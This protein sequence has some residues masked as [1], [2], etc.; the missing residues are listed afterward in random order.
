MPV[1]THT[2]DMACLPAF[3]L[4]PGNN[5]LLQYG[6]YHATSLL[7]LVATSSTD[8]RDNSNCDLPPIQAAWVVSFLLLLALLSFQIDEC[9]CL[10]IYS[11]IHFH[12][13]LTI[14]PPFS[15]PFVV[16]VR[17]CLFTSPSV[18]PVSVASLPLGDSNEKLT[19]P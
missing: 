19:L 12:S 5:Y 14:L 8:V 13:R 16:L 18:S 9:V 1:R 17:F 6:S 10:L 11:L 2:L 7:L 4:E 15:N 3:P